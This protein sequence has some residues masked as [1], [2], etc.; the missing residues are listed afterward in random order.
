[1]STE[2]RKHL[3]YGGGLLV[4]VVVAIYAYKKIQV[5]SQASNAA[6]DQASQDELAYLESMSLND[7]YAAYESSTGT[8]AAPTPPALPSITDELT[9]LEQAFGLSSPPAST[10]S[11]GTAST[12]STST[13]AGTQ[14][15]ET[16]HSL[17]SGSANQPRAAAVAT[18]SFG[19]KNSAG[20]VLGGG[21]WDLPV[22]EQEGVPVA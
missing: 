1:M 12:A 9:Q 5:N 11:S 10:S 16:T 6:S 14:A 17:P 3:I 18:G 7:P 8:S 13:S 19:F 4:L 2:T 22:M 15:S 21:S 20:P